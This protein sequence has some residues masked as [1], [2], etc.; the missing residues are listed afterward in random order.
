MVSCCCPEFGIALQLKV[1]LL[2]LRMQ[3]QSAIVV[4]IDC[5]C[6]SLSSRVNLSWFYARISTGFSFLELGF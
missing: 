3:L 4:V 2:K 5:S 1:F 6:V